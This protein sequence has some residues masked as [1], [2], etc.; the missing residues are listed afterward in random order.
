VGFTPANSQTHVVNSVDLLAVRIATGAD[1]DFVYVNPKYALASGAPWII[2][3]APGASHD[4]ELPLKDF[5]SGLNYSNLDPGT[6][7][8]ARLV[9][10]GRAAGKSATR[11]WTGKIETVLDRCS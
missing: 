10:E 3:L 2:S 6:A 4:L 9:F 11:V 7:G 1:E 5:I 8:G